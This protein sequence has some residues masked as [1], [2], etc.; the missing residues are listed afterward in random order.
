MFSL[1]LLSAR[2]Q[3]TPIPNPPLSLSVFQTF[4][5]SPPKA[6]GWPLR[7]ETAYDMVG[8]SFCRVHVYSRLSQSILVDVLYFELATLSIGPWAS[9]VCP[10]E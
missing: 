2:S 3:S 6:D 7:R 1:L 9:R 4:R 8:I 5:S 10:A